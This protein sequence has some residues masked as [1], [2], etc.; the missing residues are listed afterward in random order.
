MLAQM[1][2]AAKTWVSLLLVGL[3]I[4]AFAVFGI[5]DIFRGRT[6]TSVAKVNGDPIAAEAFA[7]EFNRMRS[8]FGAQTGQPIPTDQAIALGIDRMTLDQMISER[9]I[10]QKARELGVTVSDARLAAEITST[11][12]FQGPTGAFDDVSYKRLLR[13]NGLNAAMYEDIL[14]KAMV[15]ADVLAAL[16]TGIAAPRGLARQIHRFTGETR[17]LRYFVIPAESAGTVPEPDD[18]DLEALHQDRAFQFTAPEY[19]TFTYLLLEPEQLMDTIAV[20]DEEIAETYEFRKESFREPETRAISQILFDTA[21]AAA[22]ARQRIAEGATFRDI[23]AE[24][25][26]SEEDTAL[27]TMTREDLA[28]EQVAEAVFALEEPGVTPVIEGLFGF[29]IA[30]V[31]EIT[32]GSERPLEDVR[33]EL[34]DE[35]ALERAKDAVFDMLSRLEDGLAAGQTLEEVGNALDLPVVTLENVSQTG[36][37][38]DGTPAENLPADPGVLISAFDTEPG[39]EAPIEDTSTGGYFTVRVD[40]IVP[41][42]LRPLET[43]R[44]EVAALWRDQQLETL[45]E[46]KAETVA[47]Q[48]RNGETLE[49]V[50][51]TVGSPVATPLEPFARDDQDDVLSAPVLNDAFNAPLQGV[52]TGPDR[53]GENYVVV[54]VTNILP[55]P[56]ADSAVRALRETMSRQLT[57]D[58]GQQVIASLRN[59][60]DVTINR[61]AAIRALG[62]DPDSGQF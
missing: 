28:D 29:V 15:R 9:V 17:E 14:R 18:A 55:A 61:R 11:E 12:A 37:T 23:A 45:L 5:E 10:D 62:L 26:L 19:R 7:S 2:A 31:G 38:V 50:A 60:Y 53:T 32:P 43:V 6:D 57:E 8:R 21:E 20:S 3:L 47:D 16:G 58:L 40:Q 51:Q 39:L 44:D 48:V 30:R 36:E 25:G 56:E 35:I 27:G 34:R 1:R 46:E 33:D 54:R 42:A 13:Q 41:S 4:L 22:D 59:E 49:T 24:Q 52:V